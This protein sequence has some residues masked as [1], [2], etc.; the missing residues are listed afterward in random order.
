V[1]GLALF[2]AL[3]LAAIVVT[4]GLLALVFRAPGSARA[5]LVS[6]ALAW[7]VQ[8]FTYA[9]VRLAG[10]SRVMAAWGLGAVMRLSLLLLYAFVGV[11]VLGLPAAPALLSLATFLF[12][13]TVIESRLLSV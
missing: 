5:I 9:V 3:A 8:L 10:R 4:G 2:A 13:S 12:V 11:R 1:R 7:G 6:A